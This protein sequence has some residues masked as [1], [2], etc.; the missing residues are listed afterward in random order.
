M[1]V[2]HPRKI[3]GKKSIK[4]KKYVYSRYVDILV[5]DKIIERKIVDVDKCM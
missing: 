5:T 2:S 4:N 1:Y 3:F